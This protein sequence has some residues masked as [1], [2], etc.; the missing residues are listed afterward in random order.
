MA[1]FLTALHG[2][3]QMTLKFCRLRRRSLISTTGFCYTVQLWP[4]YQKSPNK[5]TIKVQ[6]CGEPRGDQSLFSTSPPTK[7][8]EHHHMAFTAICARESK[9][10]EL[11]FR[12]DTKNGRLQDYWRN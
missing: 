2:P 6:S 10:N 3:S 4:G 9:E 7:P 12:Q 11:E 5:Q 8:L 1:P